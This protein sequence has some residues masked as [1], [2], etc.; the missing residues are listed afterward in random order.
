VKIGEQS[1]HKFCQSSRIWDFGSIENI[2]EI[3]ISQP[4][5]LSKVDAK[6]KQ[7]VLNY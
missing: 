2:G 7:V 4:L 6:I 1:Y 3:E 5:D